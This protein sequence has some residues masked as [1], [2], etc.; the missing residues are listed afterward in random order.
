M[1]PVRS[2]MGVSEIARC[3]EGVPV[4]VGYCRYLRTLHRASSA[5]PMASTISCGTS[6]PQRYGS[7][8]SPKSDSSQVST[9]PPDKTAKPTLFFSNLGEVRAGSITTDCGRRPHTQAH[10]ACVNGP[11]GDKCC[12]IDVNTNDLLR[13]DN[14]GFVVTNNACSGLRLPSRK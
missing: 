4:D 7:L 11:F 10:C 12:R 3:A 6:T 5:S 8:E 1:V 13:G 2:G 9:N 14:A